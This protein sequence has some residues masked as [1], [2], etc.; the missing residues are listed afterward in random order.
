MNNRTSA[1]IID[2]YATQRSLSI[3]D[4]M[5]ELDHLLHED[6]VHTLPGA[7]AGYLYKTTMD[8]D[9]AI[10]AFCENRRQWTLDARSLGLNLQGFTAL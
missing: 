3:L 4:A 2:D 7:P 5:M 1:K 6:W 10:T 9:R 8:Q